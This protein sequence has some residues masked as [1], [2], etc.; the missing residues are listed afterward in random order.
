MQNL[1]LGNTPQETESPNINKM[2]RISFITESLA[3]R[4]LILPHMIPETTEE[5]VIEV[6]LQE[7]RERRKEE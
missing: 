7:K 2:L 1:F 3:V 5:E 4:N 6:A